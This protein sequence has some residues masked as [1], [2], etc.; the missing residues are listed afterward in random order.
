MALRFRRRIRLM[1]GI[2]LNFGT[3][4]MSISAGVRG[5][6]I[7]AGPR[8]VYLNAGIPGTGLSFR[9]RLS[10]ATR[11]RSSSPRASPSSPPSIVRRRVEVPVLVKLRDDGQVLIE[12]EDGQPLTQKHL[13]ILRDQQPKLLKQWIES[14]VAKLN[15]EYEA[16]VNVHIETPNPYSP[17]L[18]TFAP[19][20]EEEA[21]PPPKPIKVGLL[22]RLLLRRRQIEAENIRLSEA[23]KEALVDWCTRAQAHLQARDEWA[24]LVHRSSVGDMASME[25]VLTKALSAIVWPRETNVSLDFSHQSSMLELD[26]DLPE[27][28]DMPTRIASLAARGFRVNFK[29]RTDAEIRRD[30]LRLVNGT[31]FRIAGEAFANLPTLEQVTISAFTQRKDP[32]TGNEM[33]DYVLS[34]RIHRKD[35]CSI[36][37]EHL[38]SIDPVEALARF[39]IIRSISRGGRLEAIRPFSAKPDRKIALSA[40]VSPWCTR[41]VKDRPPVFTSTPDPLAALDADGGVKSGRR[42]A[43]IN[44]LAAVVVILFIGYILVTQVAPRQAPPEKPRETLLSG[45]AGPAPPPVSPPETKVS[46]STSAPETK[47]SRS[48]ATEAKVSTPTPTASKTAVVAHSQAPNG[49]PPA[50][51]RGVKWGIAP[52]KMMQKVGDGVYKNPNKNLN[53]YFNIPVAEEGYLFE[54]GKLLAVQLFFD[55]AD[56]FAKLKAALTKQFG[57]PNFANE[58][59]N[60]F[61]WK[62]KNPEVV[63]KLYYQEKFQRTT[64]SLTKS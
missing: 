43:S 59:S 48:S 16:C 31:V 34:A 24:S 44:R 1:P 54:D 19:F 4:G 50:E 46:T 35:W 51:F 47:V 8:G 27:I 41:D 25:F 36:D 30:Y 33:D 40:T 21:P 7:T 18:Q 61:S 12:T 28:E 20:N 6:S 55:G 64:V 32:G 63:L 53:P 62:W 58:R 14:G 10:G 22:D 42:F 3:R 17:K 45:A 9:E 2:H 49:P 5:A 11:A 56:N 15:A 23:H 38:K 39:E 37:F 52:T 60:I 26:V 57:T 13:K 29:D